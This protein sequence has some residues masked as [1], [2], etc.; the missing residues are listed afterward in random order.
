MNP[1]LRWY[2]LNGGGVTPF[3]A[4]S[5]ETTFVSS[6]V[7]GE[8][9]IPELYVQYDI[10]AG[11]NL[12]S[13]VY[14]H[15]WDG[16]GQFVGALAPSAISDL[17][18]LGIGLIGVGMRG[19]NTGA[20]YTNVGATVEEYRD[21]SG[22]EI[23]DVMDSVRHVEQVICQEG[24]LDPNRRIGYGISAGGGNLIAVMTK[25]P[26]FFAIGIDNYGMAKGG[27]YTGDPSAFGGWYDDN[28]GFQSGIQKAISGAPLLNGLVD[29]NYLSRD[30]IRGARNILSKIYMY[31]DTADLFVSVEHSDLL[32]DEFIAH[33]KDYVYHR[34]TDG[35]YDHGNAQLL[36]GVYV[37]TAQL[38]WLSDALAATRPT[39]PTSRTIHVAGQHFVDDFNIIIKR[40]RKNSPAT[41]RSGQ[42][43]NQGK[44]GALTCTYDTTTSSYTVTP[45]IP[46]TSIQNFFVEINEGS[47]RVIAVTTML[48]TVTLVP[49]VLN[50]IPLTLSQ[51]YSWIVGHNFGDT[52]SYVLDDASKVSNA[53]DLTGNQNF[54]FQPTRATRASVVSGYL[55]NGVL[56]YNGTTS[57]LSTNVDFILFTS[58]FTFVIKIDLDDTAVAD[59][60]ESLFG[61]AAGGASAFQLGT[62]S[63]KITVTVGTQSGSIASTALPGF[64]PANANLG[65]Q[66]WVIRRNSSNQVFVNMKGDLTTVSYNTASGIFGTLA[67]NFDLRVL[68]AA[69]ALTKQFQGRI[70]QFWAANEFVND[71]DMATL[72]DTL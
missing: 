16:P 11:N 52:D 14:I 67:G 43:D 2:Y 36:D 58:E 68:G 37:N 51:S 46:S 12:A 70:Y 5:G 45:I 56:Q 17:K 47:K 33:S 29:N 9:L 41:P 18:A 20:S 42:F 57:P 40:Y 38:Q 59:V 6:S 1:A 23:R 27:T 69:S 55:D 62:F 22:N 48:D 53:F 21:F 25:A 10:P 28:L 35:T 65:I 72:R 15:G 24:H 30:S 60:A 32:E 71:T 26:D 34:S 31:H 61:R 63:G 44:L 64:G 8:N 13:L 50:K 3:P 39:I 66:T 4:V 7:P 54:C 49:K 19:R